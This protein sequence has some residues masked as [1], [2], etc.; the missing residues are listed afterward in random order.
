MRGRRRLLLALVAVAVVL[1]VAAAVLVWSR[2]GST[3]VEEAVERLPSG[4]LR[5]TYTDWAAVE[6]AVP[7]PDLTARSSTEDF[8]A[9][10]DQAFDKDLTTA[11]ALSDSME[12]LAVNYGITP[13]DGEWEIYGQAEDGSVDVLQ[14]SEDVD[15][16]ALEEQFASLGYEPPA[17]GPGTDGVWDGTPEL[18]AGLD[19]PLTPVQE[20]VAVVTSERLLLMSDAPEYLARTIEAIKGDGETLATVDAVPELV[21][22]AGEATV[23]IF[24]VDDLA[25][26]ELAMFQADPT[27]AAAA[28]EMIADAGGVHPLD[29]LVMAQQP[30]LT[31]TVGMAFESSEQ[32]GEDL[33]PRTDLASGEAPGQ[34]GTFPER[35]RITDS[36]AED[37]LVTM[38]FDPVGEGPLLGDLGQGPV[39][40][41]T[42]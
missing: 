26:S 17:D 13:L 34:G 3:P 19:A 30:D 37:R 40:F 25:C 38:T 22:A 15:L 23:A 10:L 11:S 27:D 1:V 12:A 16:D 33:Q 29:G 31:M 2:L 4:T 35:F 41:A 9:F 6:K 5:A 18:V 39:L 42:C 21:E 28:N 14:L 7:D 20:N 24:W 32:A 36:V 8:D